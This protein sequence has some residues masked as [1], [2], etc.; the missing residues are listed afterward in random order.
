MTSSICVQK[1]WSFYIV[2]TSSW[3]IRCLSFGS[4]FLLLFLFFCSKTIARR[5][6]CLGPAL[7]Y[8]NIIKKIQ[9]NCLKKKMLNSSKR[10][11]I[12]EKLKKYVCT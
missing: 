5:S 6:L 7:F 10:K 8:A 1:V 12:C 3:A 11:K 4:V 9:M 2:A